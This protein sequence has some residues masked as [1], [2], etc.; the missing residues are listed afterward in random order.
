VSG[1][2]PSTDP[3]GFRR[4]S[5]LIAS[6]T[7]VLS[8]TPD[9]AN[10]RPVGGGVESRAPGSPDLADLAPLLIHRDGAAALA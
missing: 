1:V 8:S 3:I 5:L 6:P 4:L 7:P 2:V 9:V 10:R